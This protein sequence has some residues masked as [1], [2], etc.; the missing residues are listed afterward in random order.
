MEPFNGEFFR[1]LNVAVD[2]SIR[3]NNFYLVLG[4]VNFGSREFVGD[5]FYLAQNWFPEIRSWYIGQDLFILFPAHHIKKSDQKLFMALKHVID[6]IT[7]LR[8]ERGFVLV[9]W[10]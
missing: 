10:I 4:S 6:L 3:N 9:N 5:V 1:R 7:L 8:K 2:K